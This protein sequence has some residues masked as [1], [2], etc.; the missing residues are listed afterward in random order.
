MID[1]YKNN[2]QD[3]SAPADIHFIITPANVDLEIKPRALYVIS[4]GDLIL[5][6]QTGVDITYTVAVGLLPFRPVQVRVGSTATVV[7]WY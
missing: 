6:D 5:R 2:G 3:R 1:G 4:E 7:G